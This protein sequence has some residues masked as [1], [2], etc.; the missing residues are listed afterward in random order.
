FKRSCSSSCIFFVVAVSLPRIWS[1]SISR[2]TTTMKT[3]HCRSRAG[4]LISKDSSEFA[5]VGLGAAEYIPELGS[6]GVFSGTPYEVGGSNGV[7]AGETSAGTL[8]GSSAGDLGD[9]PTGAP[10]GSFAGVCGG[11]SAGALALSFRCASPLS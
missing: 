6:S 5:S 11:T 2:W 3:R 4:Q 1:R 8:G 7:T 10:G 9:S